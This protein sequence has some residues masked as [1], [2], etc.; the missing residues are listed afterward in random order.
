MKTRPSTRWSRLAVST[1]AVVLLGTGV[2]ACAPLVVGAGV[3]T[4]LVATDRRTSGAMLE[5]K[6]IELRAA[7]RLRDQIG[8]RGRVSVTSYNRRVL[9]TGEV[10]NEQDRLLAERTVAAVENVSGV[11]NEL[12]LLGVASLAQRSS[13][14]LLTGRAKAALVEARDL[15]A[16][17]F[18]V[19]TSRGTVYLMGRVT[20]REANRATEVLRNTQGVQRVVRMMEIISEE[21]LARLQ[22]KPAGVPSPDTGRNP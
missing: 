3:T 21:E 13:D 18:H 16:N 20:Q 12:A 5:D 10:A 1:L 2:S 11:F 9:L 19:T 4:V 15:F 6:G 14:L 22:P 17:A 7:N 8:E